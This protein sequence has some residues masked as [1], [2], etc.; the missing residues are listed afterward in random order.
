M[1]RRVLELIERFNLIPH[2]EGGYYAENHRS[3]LLVNR[4]QAA[5]HAGT[6]IHYLL[7]GG[8]SSCWHSI[9]ADEI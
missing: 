9:D 1:N 4:G 8:E 5:R 7:C 6:H 3:P 2:P